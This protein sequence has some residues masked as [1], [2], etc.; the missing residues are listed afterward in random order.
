MRVS[1]IKIAI[2][3]FS[4]VNMF[5]LY[6]E[7]GNNSIT[8]IRGPTIDL[9][10]AADRR[11]PTQRAD[12]IKDGVYIDDGFTGT[13]LDRPGLQ[14]MLRA[15]RQSE[16]DCILVKDFSRFARDYIALGTYL[17]QVF[18]F[19]GV[20]FISVND[21]YDSEDYRGTV[22][23]LD[24]N[25]KSLL[26]D[27]YSKDLSQKVRASLGVRKAEGRY[28]SGRTP[29]GYEKDPRD[30]YRLA[31]AEDEAQIVRRIF[32][33]TGQGYTSAQIAR[34]FNA[35]KVMTP[36]EYKIRKGYGARAPKGGVYL[37]SSST[38][39]QILRNP[40]YVGDVVSGK[41]EKDFVGGRNR[42]RP[43]EE[44]RVFHDCHE[45]IVER[46]VFEKI[47]AGRRSGK[48]SRVRKI[49][50]LAG[51]ILCGC[52]GRCL[53]RRKARKP[54]YYCHQRYVSGLKGCVE[55]VDA[56]D[57]EELV[58]GELRRRMAEAGG[59]AGGR[60]SE[61]DA[62]RYIGRIRVFDRD[63]VEIQWLSPG[64]AFV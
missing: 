6:H 55:K 31:V 2:R 57:L 50:P 37:W 44:W 40:V 63:H 12:C 25:F 1:R 41:Y 28:V 60:L 62:A 58:T 29:F 17:E 46:K 43:R 35:E 16:L 15:A 19:L 39:C 36:M 8:F 45:P 26:Y 24:V 54:Y 32:D 20:R 4:A 48:E 64:D 27:L 61:E 5:L 59:D 14:E 30:R 33:L 56:G 7:R 23:G 10:A 22:A 49:N 3:P 53:C 47:Q 52:C 18:P 21:G 42:L 51:K 11:E 9:Q 38:V 34:L 13:N